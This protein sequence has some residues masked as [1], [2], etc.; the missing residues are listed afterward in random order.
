MMSTISLTDY[1]ADESSYSN[2]GQDSP[3]E[4][5]PNRPCKDCQP[6]DGKGVHS[7]LPTGCL[8][9]LPA[10]K[11]TAAWLRAACLLVIVAVSLP[12]YAGT[13]TGQIQTATGGV[14]ANVIPPQTSVC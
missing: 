8:P 5:C 14:I 4:P 7:R 1:D 12:V 9:V 2:C 3:C 13:I 11:S 10:A 6:P